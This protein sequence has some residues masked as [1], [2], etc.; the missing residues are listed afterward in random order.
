MDRT[1]DDFVNRLDPAAMPGSGEAREPY[2]WERDH[3]LSQPYFSKEFASEVVDRF[4]SH[5]E[6]WGGRQSNVS[7]ATWAAYSAY[8]GLEGPSYSGTGLDPI[9][10]I[11][12]AGEAGEFLS[13]RMNQ[14]RGLVKHQIALVTANRPA[15]DVVARTTDSKASSQKTLTEQ[16][17][18]FEMDSKGKGL[19]LKTQYEI[20]KVCAAGFL[21]LGWNE[22]FGLDGKGEVWA[23]PLT[24][25]EVAHERVRVYSDCNWWI[26]RAYESRWDWVAKFAKDDPEKAEK[27]RG[28]S[29]DQNVANAFMYNDPSQR[30]DSDRIEVL[31]VYARP[32][33]SC[34]KGRVAIVAEG[35]LVLLDGPN[36]YGD[37][38]PITRI[39]PAEFVG[40][41]VP[42]GDSW[43]LL[44]PDEAFNACLSM[45]LTRVDAFGVPD[46]AVP[47]GSDYKPSDFSGRNLLEITPGG[48][49]PH[50]I[51]LLKIPPELGNM[52]DRLKGGM[53][54]L[55]GINSV[56][57]GN[58][59][60]NVTSGSYAALLQSMAVQFNSADE[61]A[62]IFNLERVG[63]LIIRIYQR[64]A[65][66]AQLVNICGSDE[67]WTAK[68][69]TGESLDRVERVAVKV[70]NALSKTVAGRMQMSEQMLQIPGAIQFPQELVSV[71]QTGNI[72]PLL[73]GPANKVFLI[74]SENER[75]LRGE[76]PR[77]SVLD[78]DRL[79][80][81]EHSCLMDT[82]AREDI[83]LAKSIQ[84]HIDEHMASWR[85]KT[86]KNPD[87]LEALGQPPLSNAAMVR[88]QTNA[89][90]QGQQPG[91]Q[92][93]GPRQQQ[94]PGTEPAKAKPG[95]ERAPP[96]KEPGAMPNQPEPARTP[97]GEAV[98]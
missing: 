96:G 3:W 97:S 40:T 93:P 50:A 64:C 87:L 76:Q 33:R 59:Q 77:V 28:L 95:P 2:D 31:Y 91:P 16:L 4:G 55:S 30:E 81:A 49:D 11:T 38:C 75:I 5:V 54:D 12:E 69:F 61:A 37:E 79:H 65:T 1:V 53:E 39:C 45:A 29:S 58:P 36:P 83:E 82:H 46:I 92:Q 88:D 27:I 22:H 78:D 62:W 71:M 84:A 26:F 25:W 70:A 74:K 89:Q 43:V 52:M 57:R 44:A 63:S 24:P 13:M 15:W 47:A 98:A 14:Y 21:A 7:S 35:D 8:H 73:S 34:P 41:S 19:A 94:Q 10:S 20:A 6:M 66:T 9:V 56:T 17:L 32:T 51:D 42:Y 67:A 80:I 48:G 86:M 72:K 23:L 18:D 85:D 68:E 60:E 90:T